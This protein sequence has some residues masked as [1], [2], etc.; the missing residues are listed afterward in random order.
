MIRLESLRIFYFL[1]DEVR[2]L[3]LMNDHCYLFSFE[4]FKMRCVLGNLLLL[5]QVL[6][7]DFNWWK[8]D[9]LLF[10]LPDLLLKLL[11]VNFKTRFNDWVLSLGWEEIH[12]LKW[13]EILRPIVSGPWALSL[14]IEGHFRILASFAHFDD[15]L[16]QRFNCLLEVLVNVLLCLISLF[17][18]SEWSPALELP[19]VHVSTALGKLCCGLCYFALHRSLWDEDIRTLR[20][21]LVTSSFIWPYVL[22]QQHFALK[23]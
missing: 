22:H 18:W 23:N 9:E 16:S 20:G 17:L 19:G 15:R 4:V 1:R 21:K 6:S 14:L 11:L 5:L 3:I 12:S 7:E 8:W 10:T 2:V 13:V